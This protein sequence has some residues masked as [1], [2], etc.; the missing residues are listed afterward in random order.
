MP[1]DST[2]SV[3]LV[4]LSSSNVLVLQLHCITL[5]YTFYLA[6][7]FE[8]FV[9]GRSLMVRFTWTVFVKV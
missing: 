7:Q 2:R 5:S 3:C 8:S 9:Y 6:T 4:I 1:I